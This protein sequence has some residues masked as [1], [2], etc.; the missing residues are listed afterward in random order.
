VADGGCR[1]FRW[2]Y[3]RSPIRSLGGDGV[4]PEI[5]V[6]WGRIQER[7]LALADL[8]AV[9]EPAGLEPSQAPALAL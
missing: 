7:L 6:L 9:P 4:D 8:D 2:R 1:R 3:W 5:T